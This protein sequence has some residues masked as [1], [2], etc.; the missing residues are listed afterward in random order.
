LD[1]W[2]KSYEF[3][4]IRTKSDSNPISKSILKQ[5]LTRGSF[6]LEHIGLGGSALRAVGFKE[7]GTVQICGYLFA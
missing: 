2:F 5:G 1:G 3:Y 4:K 7:E 6:L